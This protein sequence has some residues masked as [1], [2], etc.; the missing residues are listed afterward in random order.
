MVGN[1]V[2]VWRAAVVAVFVVLVVLY[3]AATAHAQPVDNPLNGTSPDPTMVTPELR[4]KMT[5]VISWVWFVL[6]ALLGVRVMYGAYQVRQDQHAGRVNSFGEGFADLKYS[7]IA[8]AL[9]ASATAIVG[10]ILFV[11]TG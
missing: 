5:R 6:L 8:L 11:T 10:G 9:C 2:W 3:L 4:N 7:A 1:R